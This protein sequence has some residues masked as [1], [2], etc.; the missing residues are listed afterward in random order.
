M[1]IKDKVV[2]IMGASSGIGAATAN[3]LAE[4]GAKLS[5]AANQR[6]QGL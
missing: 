6:H 5:I 3:L 1:S 2:V 4:K